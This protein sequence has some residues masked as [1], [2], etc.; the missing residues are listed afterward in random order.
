MVKANAPKLGRT[1]T[2]TYNDGLVFKVRV[3]AVK[4]VYGRTHYQITPEAGSG[5][6]WAQKVKLDE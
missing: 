4:G 2:V 6:R 3:L 1:G 5:E